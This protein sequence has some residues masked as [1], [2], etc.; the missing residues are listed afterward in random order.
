M[1]KKLKTIEEIDAATARWQTRLKRAVG[2]LEKLRQ[3]RKRLTK[4]KVK[5]GGY[6]YTQAELRSAMTIEPPELPVHPANIETAMLYGKTRTMGVVVE[7]KPEPV[8]AVTDIS[9]SEMTGADLRDEA[10]PAFLDRRKAGEAKD[11]ARAAEIRAEQAERKKLKA[12]GR[13]E[14]MK[15]KQAGDLKKMPLTG[16]AALDAIKNG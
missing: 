13:I 8:A 1:P 2:A 14:K 12:R 7:A 6:T 15:A 5:L 9:W 11:A 4:A 10:I 3:Q 16:R